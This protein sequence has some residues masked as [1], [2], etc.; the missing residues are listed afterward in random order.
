M[1]KANNQ[2]DEYLRII[3]QRVAKYLAETSF[4]DDAQKMI[5]L[6]YDTVSGEMSETDL[7]K[8]IPPGKKAGR[9]REG[10]N[11]NVGVLK[12]CSL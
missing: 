11:K 6:L 5:T 8:K 2:T 1:I 3:K 9:K 10:V 7:M 4:N 12:S